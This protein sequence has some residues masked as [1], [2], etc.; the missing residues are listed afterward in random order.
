MCD[1]SAAT[2]HRISRLI[3]AHE[4]MW[5]SFARH[6]KLDGYF[7]AENYLFANGGGSPSK[8]FMTALLEHRPNMKVTHF[9]GNVKNSDLED[10]A[11]VLNVEKADFFM[12]NIHW[13][14]EERVCILLNT[15]KESPRW[16]IVAKK[17]GF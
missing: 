5:D 7:I 6:L 13:V 11:E 2:F 12:E 8:R 14:I 3:D 4:H 15:P 9:Q 16:K 1:A 17:Y 10:I